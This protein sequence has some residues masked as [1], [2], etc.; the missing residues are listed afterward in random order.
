MVQVSLK[1][2]KEVDVLSARNNGQKIKYSK[3]L[4]NPDF[5]DIEEIEVVVV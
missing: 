4:G 5:K 3:R 2:N 1:Y